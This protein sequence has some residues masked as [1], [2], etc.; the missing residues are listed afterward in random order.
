MTDCVKRKP[1]SRLKRSVQTLQLTKAVKGRIS[2][3]PVRSI[4][5]MVKELSASEH[6]IRNVV[7]KDLKAKSRARIKKHLVSPSVKEKRFER[8]KK[9]LS[10][11]NKQP[12]TILFSDDNLFTVDSVSNSRT[13]RFISHQPVQAVPE[14]VKYTFKTKH[15]ESSGND[16]HYSPDDNAAFH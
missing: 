10:L 6:T 15:L 5:K 2:R 8:S 1:G 13:N 9:L 4:R 16:T 7:R 14:H 12:I 11:L 3:N